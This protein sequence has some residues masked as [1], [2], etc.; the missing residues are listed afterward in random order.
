MVMCTT[1]KEQ[2]NDDPRTVS[3]QKRVSLISDAAFIS[4][5]R[6]NVTLRSRN[7]C[8]CKCLAYSLSHLRTSLVDE[9][10]FSINS[11]S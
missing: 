9:T 1:K 6:L 7:L 5:L 10:G 3:K 2:S 8:K 11:Y 4:S